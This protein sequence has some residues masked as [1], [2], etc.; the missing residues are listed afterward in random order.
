[1]NGYTGADIFNGLQFYF[2][3]G[4]TVALTY[5]VQ[6]RWSGTLKT[7]SYANVY[8][9]EIVG[10]NKTEGA[11]NY[12]YNG[13]LQTVAV[14]K[15]D[16]YINGTKVGDDLA[17]SNLPVGTSIDSATFIGTESISNVANIFVDDV[18]VY[19]SVPSSIAK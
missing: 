19:N 8:K 6:N 1:V 12:S 7:L 2:G 11:I 5:R 15:F 13:E 17:V 3:D 16:L 18:I 9:I 14:Q 4:G 10:N